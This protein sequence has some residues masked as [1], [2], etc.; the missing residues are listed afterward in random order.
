MK[1]SRG[2]KLS[3]W[4]CQNCDAVF[5]VDYRRRHSVII[6]PCCGSENITVRGEA[7]ECRVEGDKG[8]DNK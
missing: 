8:K 7:Y 3:K 4:E 2:M 5:F 1:L 6:C